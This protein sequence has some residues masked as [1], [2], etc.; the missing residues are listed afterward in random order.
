MALP[1]TPLLPHTLP[2]HPPDPPGLTGCVQVVQCLKQRHH[3]QRTR[4]V[5]G[6]AQ[7]CCHLEALQ[8]SQGEAG[9]LFPTSHSRHPTGGYSR[10]G[11]KEGCR[12]CTCTSNH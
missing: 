6:M 2:T 5:E 10:E 4:V 9:A 12:V 3:P 7:V 1:P 11:G 8:G